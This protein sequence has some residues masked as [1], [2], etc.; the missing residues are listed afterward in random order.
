M[1]TAHSE[2]ESIDS[3]DCVKLSAYMEQKYVIPCSVMPGIVGVYSFH[4]QRVED[5]QTRNPVSVYSKSF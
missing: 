3:R 4:Y 1:F 2:E 5:G